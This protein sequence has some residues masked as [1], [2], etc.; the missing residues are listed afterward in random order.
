MSAAARSVFVFALYLF[1]LGLVLLVAPN[2]LLRTFGL[3]ETDDVWVRVV[4]M[5]VVLLGYYYVR[6]ARE[7]LTS[8]LRW[9]V[10]ARSAVLVFFVA[11]VALGFAPPIL[12]AFG[13]ID[14]AAAV[15]TALAL[16]ADAEAAP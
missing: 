11:F 8:F 10:H 3:A 7:E 5:L 9:T 13:A 16:R 1:G 14:A 15:W 6:G 4:G 2:L 12:I